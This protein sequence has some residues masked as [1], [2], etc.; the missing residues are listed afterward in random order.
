MHS[1]S[2]SCLPVIT[3]STHPTQLS[4]ALCSHG[5]F[6]R[7]MLCAALAPITDSLRGE[8]LTCTTSASATFALCVAF[9]DISAR[10]TI[11]GAGLRARSGL[12]PVLSR[13]LLIL[14]FK[15]SETQ[16]TPSTT[17]MLY[18]WLETEFRS[19]TQTS[20]VAVQRSSQAGAT[21]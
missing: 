9:V 6:R 7:Y 20:W 12:T 2:K 1:F 13:L 19:H 10:D 4:A 17:K 8:P 16:V 15:P 18:M 3:L 5:G 21:T 11:C 14:P